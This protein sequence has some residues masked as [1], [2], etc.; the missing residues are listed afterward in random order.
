MVI[1]EQRLPF[2]VALDSPNG[3]THRAIDDV[4]NRRDLSRSFS[5]VAELME[6]LNTAD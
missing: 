1:K 6:D 2:D 3:E 5:S 4:A